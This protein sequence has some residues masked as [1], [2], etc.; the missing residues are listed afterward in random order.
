M[1]RLFQV[2]VLGLVLIV[3]AGCGSAASPGASTSTTQN[4]VIDASLLEG[5]SAGDWPM[6]GYDPGHTGFVDPL[7]HPR[8]IDGKIVWT[9]RLSPI[10]SSPVA[11]LN[12]LYIAGTDGYLYALRQDSGA[13]VWRAKLNNSLTDATPSLEGQVVFVAMQ[14]KAIAAFNAET[15]QMY[16]SFS[17]GEKIQ[18]P[19]VV[20]GGRVYVASLTHLWVLDAAS[21]RVIWTFKHGASGWPTMGSPAIMGNA[22]Y[23]GLG[24]GTQLWALSLT[25][26]HVLW[27]FD[28]GDR[29]TSSPLV[30]G[31]TVYIATWQG[32][33]FAL[34]RSNGQLR[35]VYLLNTVHNQNVVDGVGGS[36]AQANNRLY[37]GDY[38]G[39]I[40]C[41]DALHG[42]LIWRFATGAQVLATPVVAGER[43]YIG[44]GD[45]FFYALD[46]KTGRPIWRYATGE[47]RGSA[48]LA[49]GR[50]YVGSLNGMVY[51]FR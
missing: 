26:G 49:N 48:S 46:S 36:M 22:V 31:D 51:A 13:V 12:M 41:I 8:T 32:K 19:P 9:R 37:M 10:F 45:G 44:S 3:L 5:S 20:V 7:V 16:W 29:I 2:F 21:G 30:Q 24:T 34:N 47:I 43:I 35:W 50:L 15:G 25:N 42:K 17:V 40:L 27:S 23:I 28:T 1:Q 33:I 39:S 11:G 38:R 18:A 6:F 4:R 14:S